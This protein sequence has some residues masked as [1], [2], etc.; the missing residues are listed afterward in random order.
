MCPKALSCSLVGAFVGER[1]R[2]KGET[3]HA[4]HTR[5]LC[6][7]FRTIM[8]RNRLANLGNS[9][10]SRSKA[11][12]PAILVILPHLLVDYLKPF[13]K[14]IH[15]ACWQ[16]CAPP[17]QSGACGARLQDCFGKLAHTIALKSQHAALV[18]RKHP[19][20]EGQ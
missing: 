20:P 17:P 18:A 14:E 9:G 6:R 10:Q 8:L 1:E 16:C 5:A 13:R 11:R 2:R 19:S 7:E 12:L 4:T 15:Q 3:Q